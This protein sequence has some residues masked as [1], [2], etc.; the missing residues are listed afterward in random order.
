MVF[1][2]RPRG[3]FSWGF[4]GLRLMVEALRVQLGRVGFR[5][6]RFEVWGPC[7]RHALKSIPSD[8]SLP[9]F[10]MLGTGVADARFVFRNATGSGL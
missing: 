4:Y 3:G 5:A 7:T 2:T 10:I 8:I 1:P 9:Y 6:F